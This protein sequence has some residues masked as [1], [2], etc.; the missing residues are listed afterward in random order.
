[1]PKPPTDTSQS[2]PAPAPGFSLEALHPGNFAL[3]MASGIISIGFST[4][5][6]ELLADVVCVFAIV[7]WVTLL[8]LNVGRFFMFSRAVRIDLLNP[9]M[10]FSFFT[11]VA[12]TDIVGLLLNARG[13]TG[14]AMGCWVIA[15]LA[16]CL[17]LYLAFSVLTFLSHE[18][19]VNIVHG[20]WLI[21]IVGTQSLVLLGAAI[22]PALGEYAGYMMVE[23][24]MLWGLGLLFYGIF[25]TLFCYRIFFLALKP[26]DISPL[27]WVIMGAAAISANAGTSLL[28]EDPYLPFLAAQRPFVE[29]VTMMIWAW[30][31][32]WIPMLLMFGFWKHIARGL[33]LKYEPAMWSFVFPLGMYTVASA[34]LGLAAEFPPLQWISQI[35]IWV[36]F[37]VWLFVL[38]GLARGLLTRLAGVRARTAAPP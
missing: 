31:T 5:H 38:G 12:A 29:G 1:M 35:M 4:L 16:W 15:F 7:A 27:L 34:R 2:A 14:L 36:A 19:N 32:W 6:H 3:V 13:H 8:T 9:R 26:Q 18:N 23:V 17:L 22:A 28:S 37:A 33:P 10:V 21:S 24:H 30:G 11:L 20:G 25:V